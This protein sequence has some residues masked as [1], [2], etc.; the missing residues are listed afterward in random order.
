MKVNPF[1]NYMNTNR[2]E[3]ACSLAY[4]LRRINPNQTQI[5]FH[6]GRFETLTNEE[7]QY[8]LVETGEAEM[9][10]NEQS[11]DE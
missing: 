6:D 1:V 8:F 3:G 10:I 4:Q 5:L 2:K 11:M 7:L 9:F